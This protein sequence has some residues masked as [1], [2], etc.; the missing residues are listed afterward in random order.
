[1]GPVRVI[2]KFVTNLS[3]ESLCLLLVSLLASAVFLLYSSLSSSFFEFSHFLNDFFFASIHCFIWSSH[4]F[5]F[6][7]LFR[8]FI[9]PKFSF[10]GDFN[11]FFK[12]FHSFS[13]SISSSF[14]LLQ[15]HFILWV[16][17]HFMLASF[18]NLTL[19]NS[20]C[21]YGFLFYSCSTMVVEK[22]LLHIIKN[23]H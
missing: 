22:L 6:F 10:A 3:Q 15:W 16:Y 12:F 5:K 23:G 2:S 18:S 9:V 19:K 21:L 8:H 11:M 20:S 14:V 13:M 17:S 4:I 1:L 7:L